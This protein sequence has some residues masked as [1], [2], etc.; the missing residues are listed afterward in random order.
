MLFEVGF[1]NQVEDLQKRFIS[2]RGDYDTCIG[3]ETLS[4]VN[5]VQATANVIQTT[6]SEAHIRALHRGEQQQDISEQ[7]L[8]NLSNFR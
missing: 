1:G 8:I 6:V 5:D 2:L 4:A 7:E 3:H